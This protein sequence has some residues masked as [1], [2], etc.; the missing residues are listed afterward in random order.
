TGNLTIGRAAPSIL[1]NCVAETVEACRVLSWERQGA[2][3]VF[4]RRV[5]LDDY[6]QTG[7]V[8]DAAVTAELLRNIFYPKAPL[9]DGAVIVQNGRITGAGCV[10]PLTG[11]Q[12]LS[13]DL[14]MRHR[15]GIGVSENSDAVV[16]IV[17]EETGSVSVAAGGML[18][19]HLAPETLE[20]LLRLEL[21]PSDPQ[22][23]RKGWGGML[24]RIREKGDGA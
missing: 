16:V 2:L 4:E 1:E 15:A 13:R 20:K 14:G 23:G 6:A 5:L 10:L 24:R 19:R 22:D 8:L 21:L 18:K 17:S 3:I 9:H 7:T 11:N 12:N